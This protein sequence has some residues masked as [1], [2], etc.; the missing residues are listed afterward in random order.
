MSLT[1]NS[2]NKHTILIFF[3][4]F[5]CSDDDATCEKYMPGYMPDPGLQHMWDMLSARAL[6]PDKPLP[7]VADDIKNLLEQ[8]E[9]VKKKCTPVAERIKDLFSLEKKKPLKAKK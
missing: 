8:P 7:P 9:F 4:L 6:N 5:F 2:Y 3:I 1:F